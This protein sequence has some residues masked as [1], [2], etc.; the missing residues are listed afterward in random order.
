MGD[1]KGGRRPL[2]N[3]DR[4]AIERGLNIGK[5]KKKYCR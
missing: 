4:L 2:T 3:D 1:S 5:V